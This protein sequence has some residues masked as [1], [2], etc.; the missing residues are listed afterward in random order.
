MSIKHKPVNSESVLRNIIHRFNY[1]GDDA[2]TS[3]L[4]GELPVKTIDYIELEC[5]NCKH[6]FRI[7]KINSKCPKCKCKHSEIAGKVRYIKLINN[8]IDSTLSMEYYNEG[9]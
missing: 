6:I 8:P 9:V 5:G 2:N 4:I 7:K 3:D 1:V